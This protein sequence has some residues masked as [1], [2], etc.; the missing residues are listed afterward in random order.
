MDHTTIAVQSAINQWEL[1]VNYSSQLLSKLPDEVLQKQIAPSKNTGIYVLG[2]LIAIHDNM[3]P[4]LGIGISN[5]PELTEAYIKKPDGLASYAKAVKEI[6]ELW[7]ETHTR[8]STL[9]KALPTE[10]WL[11]RH[12]LMTDE[13]FQANPIRNRLSLLLSRINHFS[14]HMGQLRLLLS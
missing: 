11:L 10:Q 2:H 8:V 5:Y 9:I 3:L 14:Y 12:N 7:K 6:R 1:Y 4:E 13:D